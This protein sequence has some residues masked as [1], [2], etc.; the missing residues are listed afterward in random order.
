[1]QLTLIKLSKD[2]KIIKILI[3]FLVVSN[4]ANAESIEQKL[5]SFPIYTL[6]GTQYSFDKID[7]ELILVNFWA[8]W[9]LYCKEE[10]DSMFKLANDM[11]GKLS[12]LAISVDEN[13]YDAMTYL[14]EIKFQSNQ[15]PNVYFAIDQN[16][17]LYQN[18]FKL[19]SIPTTLI[20]KT[21]KLSK[22]KTYLD[23]ITGARD[24]QE[25]DISKYLN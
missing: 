20:I 1:M 16:R 12:I 19:K 5:K 4:S 8:S 18:I 13:R 9:C 24:W 23:K 22:H 15:N 11:N 17:S 3:L 2:I 21:D 25:M 10:F 7:H 6:G 14:K